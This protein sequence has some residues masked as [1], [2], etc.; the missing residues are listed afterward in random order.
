MKVSK[1][2]IKKVDRLARSADLVHDLNVDLKNYFKKLGV[3]EEL[4]QDSLTS[5]C[6]GDISGEEFIIGMLQTLE[7]LEEE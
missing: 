1:K 6:Y 7:E 3:P 5:L 4:T 2:L